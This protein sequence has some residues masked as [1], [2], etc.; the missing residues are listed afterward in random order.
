MY[1][2]ALDDHLLMIP[3][4]DGAPRFIEESEQMDFL[5]AVCWSLLS[6]QQEQYCSPFQYKKPT[7]HAVEAMD[8]EA[9]SSTQGIARQTPI[10]S[11]TA[12]PTNKIWYNGE[13]PSQRTNEV[14]HTC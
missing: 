14:R 11:R 13:Q 4:L 5:R 1:L 8:E 12:I 3:C 2:G 10:T 6:N 7:G 9:S